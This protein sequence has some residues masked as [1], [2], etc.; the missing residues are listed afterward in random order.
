[1]SLVARGGPCTSNAPV[2][3]SYCRW[4]NDFFSPSWQ[5]V[6]VLD[7]SVDAGYSKIAF[8][9]LLCFLLSLFFAHSFRSRRIGNLCPPLP[10]APTLLTIFTPVQVKFFPPGASAS[11][12]FSL[13]L[14]LPITFSLT[15]LLKPRS[16]DFSLRLLIPQG[17]P[18]S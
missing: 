14:P 5:F 13:P 18:F 8:F 9:L 15:H 12:A 4:T 1:M 11:L 16:A 3:P 7:L 17:S 10:V 2:P 6:Y